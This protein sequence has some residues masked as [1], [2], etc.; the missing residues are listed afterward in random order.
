M[1]ENIDVSVIIPVY[2]SATHLKRAIDSVLLQGVALEI[3]AV[4][5]ASADSSA[6]ILREY[7]RTVPHFR[8]ITF[9]QNRGVGAAR[10]EALSFASGKYLAFCDSDDTVPHGAYRAL[11]KS[12]RGRDI[13]I[14]AYVNVGEDGVVSGRYKP[15]RR[16]N[17]F[18]AMFSVC[19]LWNKL[20]RREFVIKNGLNFDTGMTIG[21]D[22]VFL[23]HLYNLAPTYA[24]TDKPVYA[25]H[26][27]AGS[28]IHTYTFSSFMKHVES[29]RI[30]L[31]VCQ[32][33]EAEEYVSVELTPFLR[34]FLFNIPEAE[35]SL[36]FDAY[37]EFLLDVSASMSDELF[38]AVTGVGR[39]DFVRVGARE[40][41]ALLSMA[42]PRERVLSEY[43]SGAIGILWIIKFFAAWLKYKF[44]KLAR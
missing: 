11:L 29:R 36:A 10:R 2:N 35:L 21:E 42:S 7:E 44:A 32:S 38:V 22:V 12:V 16:C 41:M 25:H 33:P 30:L 17:L 5:D 1:A 18:R 28:L 43:R 14:G 19:C 26:L 8:L 15:P 40:Y 34:N 37:R 24:T 4:D 27:R 3:I 31:A 9:K 39:D 13:A 23:G 20:I 6:D